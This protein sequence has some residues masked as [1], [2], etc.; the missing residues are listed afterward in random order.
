[1]PPRLVN[2]DSP[3][4]AALCEDCGGGTRAHALLADAGQLSELCS[5]CF[6]ASLESEEGRVVRGTLALCSPGDGLLARSFTIPAPVTVPE[7]VALL[8]ASPRTPL[9][10][11]GGPAG[12]EIWGLLDSEPADA[13]R[14]RIAGNG[15]LLA[16]RGGQV[17]AVM[18]KGAVARPVASGT[19][20]L[21]QLVARTL[22]REE[23]LETHR[24]TPLHLIRII[25]AIIASGHG[26]MVLIVPPGDE[27]WRANVSFRYHF[28]EAGGRLLQ[29]SMR[30]VKHGLGEATRHYESLLTGGAAAET[31]EALR[32]QYDDVLSMQRLTESL[33]RRVGDLA[34]VD[35][36]VV[37][38]D[39]L[40]L[41]G[42]GA[43]LLFGPREFT[44][45]VLN[46]VTGR[47]TEGVP[48][49]ALGGTRHQS[50]ARFVE[51]NRATDAM[52]V[53]QEGRLSMFS[54]SERTQALAVIQ[55][56]EH[57]H[58]EHWA[59]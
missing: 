36:A 44:V 41:Y 7:L 47:M 56:L 59:G 34:R 27:S 51:A 45:T 24:D 42:F 46:A 9:A 11:H 3:L 58:W 55:N 10:V 19:Q 20:E 25:S 5:L 35:G 33:L 54:W 15:I 18:N 8:T 50:A 28:D 53:S 1:M 31:L 13:P 16:S 52:V 32:V 57:F 43:K 26:G 12:L 37:M 40:K 4:V 49:S 39:G 21:S 17:L 6:W 30:G 38:D 2:A 23:F 48:L 29:D 22:G 14:L